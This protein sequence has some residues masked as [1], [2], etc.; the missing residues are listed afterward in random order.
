MRFQQTFERALCDKTCHGR[1]DLCG[2]AAEL[3]SAVFHCTRS[4]R[5]SR[6][7]APMSRVPEAHVRAR[8]VLPR[9]Q[10]VLVVDD[11]SDIRQIWDLWLTFW[12]FRVEEAANGAEALD[13]AKAHR[14]DLVLMDIWMPV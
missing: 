13:K 5:R 2:A 7:Y 11:D 14:P 12:G 8:R 10:R 1:L 3:A 6:P 4:C 9:P